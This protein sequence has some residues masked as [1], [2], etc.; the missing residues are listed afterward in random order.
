MGHQMIAI[1]MRLG[2][3]LIVIAIHLILFLVFATKQRRER[4]DDKALALLIVP[5]RS[6]P[7]PKLAKPE[8]A[9]PIQRAPSHTLP[10]PIIPSVPP[11]PSASSPPTINWQAN[12]TVAAHDAVAKKLREEGYRN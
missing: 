5:L 4:S 9:V 2:T 11:S 7:T 1:W 3:I 12:A 6:D 10:I 8:L